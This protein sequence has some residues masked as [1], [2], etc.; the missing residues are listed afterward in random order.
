MRET[1]LLI[2]ILDDWID[3][4]STEGLVLSTK[5]D[6]DSFLSRVE[7]FFKENPNES[8]EYSIGTNQTIIHES[9][10]SVSQCFFTKEI[11]KEEYDTISKTVGV[12]FGTTSL[13]DV[14]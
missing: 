1:Y 3:E 13:M 6:F 4:I 9:F 5:K 7:T 8:L 11:T 2:K 14:I 12:V 10:S